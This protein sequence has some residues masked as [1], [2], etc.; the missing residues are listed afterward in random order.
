MANNKYGVLLLG[1]YRT[2]QE[3]YA[4]MFAADPRCQLIACSDELDAPAD[5]VELNM[6]LADELNLPYIT[7]LDQALALTDVNIVSLC[8]EMERRGVIGKNALK[9]GNTFI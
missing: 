7:D 2:H 5:R 9:Q 8:V 4:L 3:N 1:G 6:Q